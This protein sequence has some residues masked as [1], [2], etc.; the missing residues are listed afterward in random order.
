MATQWE[1]VP[2]AFTIN[3]IGAYLMANLARGL[4]TG[5]EVIREY[6]Q[7]AGTHTLNSQRRL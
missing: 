5:P 6:I 4:Y 1:Y 7:N 2:S 3:D